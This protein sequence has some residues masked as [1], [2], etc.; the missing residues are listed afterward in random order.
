ML[1]KNHTLKMLLHKN[2]TNQCLNLKFHTLHRSLVTN[3][4]TEFIYFFNSFQL[5]LNILWDFAK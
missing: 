2:V 1:T 5:M 4:T 3:I